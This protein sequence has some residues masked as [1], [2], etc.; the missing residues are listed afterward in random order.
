MRQG[1]GGLPTAGTVTIEAAG[2]SAPD[3]ALGTAATSTNSGT[4][5]PSKQLSGTWHRGGIAD[6]TRS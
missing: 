1:P 5:R 4:E 2:G 6:L 3:A